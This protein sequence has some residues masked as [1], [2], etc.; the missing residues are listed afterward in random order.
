MTEFKQM[1]E[2]A[3][4]CWCQIHHECSEGWPLRCCSIWVN[5]TPWYRTTHQD[6]RAL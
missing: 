5:S 2:T 4:R 6:D 3:Y 1:M